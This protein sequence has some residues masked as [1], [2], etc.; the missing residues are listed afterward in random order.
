MR[1]L[2][3]LVLLMGCET[4]TAGLTGADDTG[5]PGRG[6]AVGDAVAAPD[7]SAP[8]LSP[9]PDLLPAPDLFV[10]PDIL[11][12]LAPTADC[13]QAIVCCVAYQKALGTA[14]SEA[15]C[16][17]TIKTGMLGTCCEYAMTAAKGTSLNGCSPVQV[18]SSGCP[19]Y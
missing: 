12:D 4:E 14:A 7:A 15:D 18:V 9:A 19:N 17:N 6:S 13:A 16:W 2:L 1:R 3:F 10:V 11:P 5:A 8:D